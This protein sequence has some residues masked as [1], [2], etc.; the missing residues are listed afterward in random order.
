LK[1]NKKTLLVLGGSLGAKAINELI[2]NH[3]DYF[4][5]NNIQV[6]WQCGKLYKSRFESYNDLEGVQVHSFLNR[7][8]LAYAGA[9]MIISR[10]GASSVSELCIVGKPV[11]FIPSPYVAEDH[12]TKNAQAIVEESSAIL[13]AQKDLETQFKTKFSELLASEELQRA[14][15]TNIKKLALI[16]ATKDIVDQV[17]QL[18]NK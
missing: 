5:N 4:K 14:L 1:K 9:D 15:S 17:E 12:Q 11:I 18:L 10:A 8:D 6:I 16:N 2:E 13:I 3:I 7:M